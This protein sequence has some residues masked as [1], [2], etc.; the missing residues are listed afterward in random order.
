MRIKYKS[1]VFSFH[2]TCLPSQKVQAR[3]AL[4]FGDYEATSVVLD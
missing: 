2:S 4:P 3:L 1:G